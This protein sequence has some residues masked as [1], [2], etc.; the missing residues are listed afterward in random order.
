[1]YLNILGKEGGGVGVNVRSSLYIIDSCDSFGSFDFIIDS[2][3][4]IID[5]F[6][7]IIDSFDFIIDSCDC[8]RSMISSHVTMWFLLNVY[9]NSFRLVSRIGFILDSDPDSGARNVSDPDSGGRNVPDSGV[10]NV[11]DSGA[12]NA[13]DSGARNV[14]DPDSQRCTLWCRMN[15]TRSR[16]Y[17]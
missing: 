11:K 15:L 5:S 7:F 14:P 6:D 3:D 16:L 2:F 9:P 13:P 12:R 4:F 8:R 17:I 1:M 10:R